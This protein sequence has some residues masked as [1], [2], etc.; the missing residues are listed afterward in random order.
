MTVV[1]VCAMTMS[2]VLYHHLKFR[3][4]EGRRAR[5]KKDPAR[6]W[7]LLRASACCFLVVEIPAAHRTT[8]GVPLASVLWRVETGP[9]EAYRPG[10]GLV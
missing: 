6:C 7:F 4:L 9:D 1:W 10:I 8:V 2:K 5:S 3:R